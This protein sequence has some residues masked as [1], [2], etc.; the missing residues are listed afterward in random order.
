MESYLTSFHKA[1]AELDTLGFDAEAV[2]A[3]AHAEDPLYRRNRKQLIASM[4]VLAVIL[5]AEPNIPILMELAA[6]IDRG[7]PL[8]DSL[9]EL[10]QVRKQSIRY[11]TGKSVLT[12]GSAW[13]TSPLELFVAINLLPQ[14]KLP[15]SEQDW[16][17]MR[18]LWEGSGL[19][20]DDVYS[21]QAFFVREHTQLEAHFFTGLCSGGYQRIHE[22]LF[23]LRQ[24]NPCRLS[25]VA[26]YFV[27]VRQW[28][29][30]LWPDSYDRAGLIADHLLMRYSA[31]TLVRQSEIWHQ[32]IH[33]LRTS[34]PKPVDLEILAWWPALPGLPWISNG[35]AIVALNTP[36]ALQ[37]EGSRLAHCVAGYAYRCVAGNSHIVSLRNESGESA[38]TAEICCEIGKSKSIEPRVLQHRGQ[39][40]GFPAREC[41]AALDAWLARWNED[42]FQSELHKLARFHGDEK[43]R[44]EVGSQFLMEHELPLATMSRLMRNVLPDYEA[45]LAWLDK[46]FPE[47]R[48]RC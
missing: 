47:A 14:E 3:W 24:G 33:Q 16:T 8:I 7:N 38:S 37:E 6:V 32:R 25:D 21:R 31:L 22:S 43:R 35:L 23:K 34:D 20:S 17:F 36:A 13:L 42:K 4:P 11:L 10:I 46:R 30:A 27:F 45:S 48:I 28:C 29:Q 2:F 19:G 40:N 18:T 39:E 5:A 41:V 26:D 12:L 15:Q 44:A 9:A 1:L